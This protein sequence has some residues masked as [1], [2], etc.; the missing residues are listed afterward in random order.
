MRQRDALLR[1]GICLLAAIAI[2]GVT[3]AWE[4]PFPFRS[5]YVPQRDIAARVEFG[6]TD[7]NQIEHEFMEGDRL[8]KAGQPLSFRDIEVLHTE[9]IAVNSKI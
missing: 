7:K 5:G 3:R 9:H 4:P 2:W 1:I 6:V 8:V